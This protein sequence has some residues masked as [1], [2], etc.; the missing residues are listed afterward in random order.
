MQQELLSF[1]CFEA[2][3][4][5]IN[6]CFTVDIN[7]D[8]KREGEIST[9]RRRTALRVIEGSQEVLHLIVL[10]I[11]ISVIFGCF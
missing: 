8:I 6:K 9:F 1:L 11:A 4:E 2:T 3:L 10:T 5:L 7:R